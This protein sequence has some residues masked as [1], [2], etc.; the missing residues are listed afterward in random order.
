MHRT[1]R[2][3][4]IN[5][6]TPYKSLTGF[7]LGIQYILSLFVAPPEMPSCTSWGAGTPAYHTAA[8]MKLTCVLNLKAEKEEPRK[9]ARVMQVI[10]TLT[11]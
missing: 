7:L 11:S 4:L 3:C 5:V 10:R 1:P 8:P 9:M 2:E 6:R